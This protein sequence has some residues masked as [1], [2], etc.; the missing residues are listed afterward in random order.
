MGGKEKS[1]YR[2]CLISLLGFAASPEFY[3]P[4]ATEHV[5]PS[6]ELA[7]HLAQHQTVLRR[8]RPLVT[9]D[10]VASRGTGL[11]PAA[12]CWLRNTVLRVCVI[13]IIMHYS[14]AVLFASL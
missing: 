8:D 2:T 6:S 1:C 10:F 5:A 3:F 4:A 13:L 11:C 9:E 12:C 7:G 14:S